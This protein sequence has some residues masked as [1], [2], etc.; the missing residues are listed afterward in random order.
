M[1]RTSVDEMI[2]PA[3][4]YACLLKTTIIIIIM[5]EQLVTKEQ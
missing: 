5:L 3:M 2:S 4:S 1:L